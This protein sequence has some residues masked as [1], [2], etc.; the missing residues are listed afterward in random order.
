MLIHRKSGRFVSQLTRSTMAVIMAGGRGS[1]LGELTAT[2]AK[3]AV[4]VGASPRGTLA[5][6]QASRAR[7]VLAGRDFVVPED[8]KA[9]AVAALAH[10][11]ALR[12]DLWVQGLRAEQVVA[13]CL[14]E[15]PTPP[16]EPG[17]A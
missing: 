1:R 6:L 17:P 3:P 8:V 16:A 4:D 14:A 5:L 9:L 11:I 2:R 13:E 7:A 15:V 10:R 12:P